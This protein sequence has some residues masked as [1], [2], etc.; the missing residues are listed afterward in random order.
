MWNFIR[1]ELFI[2]PL[3]PIYCISLTAN[4]DIYQCR[5]FRQIEKLRFNEDLV[6]SLF[7]KHVWHKP[8]NSEKTLTKHASDAFNNFKRTECAVHW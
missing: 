3:F 1:Y 8:V 6:L 5:N 4:E 7:D 2:R